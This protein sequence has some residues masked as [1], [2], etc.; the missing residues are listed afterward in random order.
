MAQDVRGR[1]PRE[2]RRHRAYEARAD[3]VVPCDVRERRRVCRAHHVH[4]HPPA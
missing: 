2:A 1:E 3:A 4:R